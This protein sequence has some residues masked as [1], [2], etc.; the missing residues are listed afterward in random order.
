M[1]VRDKINDVAMAKTTARANGVNKNFEGP[2][3]KTTG[4]KTMHMDNMVTRAGKII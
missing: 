2:T 1:I 3:N 4:R